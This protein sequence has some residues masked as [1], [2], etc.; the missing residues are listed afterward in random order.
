MRRRNFIAG[1]TAGVATA[2]LAGCRTPAF[3][4]SQ[5]PT[6]DAAQFR[7]SLRWQA[8]RQGRIAYVDVGVGPAALFIHGFPL[9]GFQWR[10]VLPQ[11]SAERRCLAPD[12]MGLGYSEVGEKESLSPQAQCNMLAEFLNRLNVASVDL[13]ASDSGGTIAQLLMVQ[14]PRRVRSVLLTNCDVDENSPPPQM[15]K[16]I[17]AARAG[18]YDQKIANHLADPAYARSSKGIGGS[19]YMNP[20]VFSNEVIDYHFRPLVSS[21]LRRAQLNRHL[22]EFEPN[23]LLSIETALQQSPIPARM[24]WGTE[25]T[26]FPIIWARWLDSTLPASRGIREVKGGKLFWPEERPDILVHEARRL[27]RSVPASRLTS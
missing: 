2:L 4:G 27:W 22:A 1:A 15:A 17:A 24:V 6:L 9:S 16:S 11:L 5:P 12:L 18:T 20:A 26:L 7:S 19:A 14:H 21:A 3:V 10:G 8:T 25:D 23:P 13:V